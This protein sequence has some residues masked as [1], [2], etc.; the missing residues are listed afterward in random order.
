M[1]LSVLVIV[2]GQLFVYWFSQ[3][4]RPRNKT[5]YVYMHA[6]RLVDLYIGWNGYE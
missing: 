3:Y 6:D 4:Y 5:M 1:W 2:I